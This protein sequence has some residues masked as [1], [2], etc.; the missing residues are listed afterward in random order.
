MGV[1]TVDDVITKTNISR[2]DGLPYFL[3]Y[4]VPRARLWLLSLFVLLSPLGNF[5]KSVIF[6]YEKEK[7][8]E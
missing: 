5:Q 3:N 4:G 1:W 6:D 7:Q 8:Q 2:I